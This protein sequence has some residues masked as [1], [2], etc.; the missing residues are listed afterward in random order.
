M[1]PASQ[2]YELDPGRVLVHDERV[3]PGAFDAGAL[4]QHL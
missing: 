1:T 3:V 4:R 2:S